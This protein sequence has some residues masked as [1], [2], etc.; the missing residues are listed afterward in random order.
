MNKLYSVEVMCRMSIFVAVYAPPFVIFMAPA[1]INGFPLVISG[2]SGF[3]LA[4]AIRGTVPAERPIYYSLFLF[5][6]HWRATLWP[7]I[8]AQSAMTIAVL[9]IFLRRNLAPLPRPHLALLLSSLAVFT[10]LPVVASEIMPDIF[11]PLMILSLC[12]LIFRPSDITLGERMFLYAVTLAALCFH[13]ANFLI[14]SLTVIFA[15]PFRLALDLSWHQFFRSFAAL[16]SL[17][18]LGV[19][20]L[21]LPNYI[22]YHEIVI[23]RGG[24]TFLLAKQIDNGPGLDYLTAK[25]RVQDYSICSQLPAIRHYNKTENSMQ[26]GASTT[27]YFLWGGP[28]SAAGGWDALAP[29]A[30]SIAVA[31]ILQ[32]P[33]TFVLASLAGFAHQLAQFNTGGNL[34]V[35]AD[36]QLST[37]LKEYFW[38]GVNYA[39]LTSRQATGRLDLT[40]VAY[41][42]K[43]SVVAGLLVIIIFLAGTF[44][45]DHALGGTASTLLLA[46]IANAAVTGALSVAS[47]R[48]QSRVVGLIVI[49]AMILAYARL[50]RKRCRRC[51]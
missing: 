38:S 35:K 34:D 33:R 44:S 51:A 16:G 21:L 41:F 42:H 24:G 31:S 1:L 36:A 15:I 6:L 40:T 2:D 27:E 3:Y 22:A 20:L 45:T 39:Y 10:S 50:V 43:L 4:T 13:A 46:V 19:G 37:A 14:A 30:G 48:Y 29:Y 7:P 12:I 18:A 47:D 5:P 26:N 8:A 9:D 49:V 25:C 11:T 23:T 28:L 17:L 32:E